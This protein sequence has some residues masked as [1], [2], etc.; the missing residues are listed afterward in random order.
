MIYLMVQAHVGEINRT[1]LRD[2]MN[3]TARCQAMMVYEF[4]SDAFL[5]VL[6]DYLIKG[7]GFDSLQ[8]A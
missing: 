1:H 2:L 7:C 6:I 4:D 3:D 5:F 8:G